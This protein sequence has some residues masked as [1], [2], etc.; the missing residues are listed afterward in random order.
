MFEKAAVALAIEEG[1][2]SYSSRCFVD[3]PR[4]YP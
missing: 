4:M 2:L 3:R 1:V